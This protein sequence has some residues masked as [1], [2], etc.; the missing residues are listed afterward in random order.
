MADRES[1]E[2]TG[3]TE[4]MTSASATDFML[5]QFNETVSFFSPS[6]LADV[7]PP[8]QKMPTVIG[9]YEIL[10]LLGC[11]GF[12]AVYRGY[13]PHLDRQVAIK[14]PLLN[15]SKPLADLFPQEASKI[16]QL[17]HPSIVTVHDVGMHEGVCYIVSEYLDGQNLN[18]WMQ[19]RTITWPEAAAI[20]AALA[21][22]LAAAHAR[23]IIH[24][25]VKPANVIMTQCAD[26]FVPVL[27]DFG[28]ALSEAFPAGVATGAGT[29]TGTP[30][31]MSPEQARGKG[32]R[33]DGRTDIYALGVILYRLISGRLP[34]AGPDLRALLD[35]VIA[36]EPRPPRQFVRGLPRELERICLK[37]MAKNLVDRYTTASDLAHD[38]RA[39]IREHEDQLKL[40]AMSARPTPA[41]GKRDAIQILIADDH[42]LSRFKLKTDLEKWGHEVIAAEDGEQ[43]WELFQRHNF[44][45]V[46]TDW[47]MPK[48]DGLELVKMIR[49][50][51]C[52]DYVY[53]IMLTAKA[54]KHDIVAGMGAGADDFLTKPFH[55]D[56][57]QVR[58][59][60]GIRITK[61]N[62]QLNETNR[63]LE[64]GS[65]AAA[66]IQQSFLPTVKPQY[67]GCTF[68][69]GHN[70]CGKLGGDMFNAVALGEGRVGIYVL[71]VTGEGVP[72]ALLATTLSRVLAPISD[73]TSILV[74]RR[75]DGSAAR[76][77]EPV[78]V[79]RELNRRFGTQEGKQ[80]FTLAYGVLH[81]ESRRFEFTSAGHPPLLYL[82][83]GRPPIM[84][85]VEGYAIGMAPES[86]PFQQRSLALQPGDRLL[87]YS[88]G[89][90]D[91]MRGDGEVFGA[92][93]LLDSVRRSST[94]PLDG[95][96]E[97][98]LGE[99]RDWR[100]DA[101][102]NEDVSI[103]GF[104]MS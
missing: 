21:D 35:A 82:Q 20:T 75:D 3:D 22:A 73:H 85:D 4:E 51:D 66:Q 14:V 6:A 36:H 15:P 42:E 104:T 19:G 2:A 56:E 72:A 5:N 94:E 76:V 74:E 58:L 64:R 50:A 26:E 68:A 1:D 81:L 60:A 31:Y 25:D 10:G 38:L 99:L 67:E 88:D 17:K 69:W 55:R 34:F 52:A 44:A 24:R 89:V 86:D 12:G 61:L 49:A 43:A 7:T 39:V 78:E 83:V 91:A 63:R 57:L 37:A 97:G 90:P 62:R 79:A 48:M 59:R 100:G 93:R 47:M 103:L 18:H 23:S 54:E 40:A 92:A 87:I 46:I 28:L 101:D 41:S 29:I 33:I 65:E 16:A 96:I 32:N 71:D 45:I 98:L 30:N 95:V 53:I 80:Y 77:R 9:R 13:D 84:L 102:A 8:G 70:P 11:G 27:V